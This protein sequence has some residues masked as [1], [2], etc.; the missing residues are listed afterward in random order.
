[1]MLDVKLDVLR[2]DFMVCSFQWTKKSPTTVS[3]QALG[4][5]RTA[6]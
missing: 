3:G 1:V 5:M 4:V 2:C 6:G